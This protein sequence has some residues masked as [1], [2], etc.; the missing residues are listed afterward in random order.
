MCAEAGARASVGEGVVWTYERLPG[1][2]GGGE[3]V[4]G[5][6]QELLQLG[7][8]PASGR[9]D[10]VHLARWA[11][12]RVDELAVLRELDVRPGGGCD[13]TAT[14]ISPV[15]PPPISLPPH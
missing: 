12:G 2:V 7:T 13:G 15:P 10:R 3:L 9:V 5:D 11:S 1:L 8:E 4:S 14:T 6:V